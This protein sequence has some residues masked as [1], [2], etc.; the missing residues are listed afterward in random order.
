LPGAKKEMNVPYRAAETM[1]L[2]FPGL[3]PGLTEPALQ[4]GRPR[5]VMGRIFV[6]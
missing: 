2:A 1:G 5:M 6:P 4:A 3:R